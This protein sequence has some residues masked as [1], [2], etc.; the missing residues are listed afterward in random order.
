ME[1]PLIFLH[2]PKTGGT[3]FHSML[4]FQYLGRPSI[5]LRP[6]LHTDDV[7]DRRRA[8]ELDELDDSV[9]RKLQ[10]VRGHAYYG[11]HEKMPQACTYFTFVRDP[12]SH[13]KSQYYY[14]KVKP[15]E[16]RD[17][18]I[19]DKMSLESILAD[20]GNPWLDNMQ[21]RWISGVGL[22]KETI[23]E[24]EYRLAQRNVENHFSVLGVT[25][26]FDLSV[27]L[28]AKKLNWRRPLF[29]RRANV[30]NFNEGSRKSVAEMPTELIK[31]TNTWDLRLY[32]WGKKR[33]EREVSSD[34]EREVKNMKSNNVVLG[35]AVQA[36]RKVRSVY[37]QAIKPYIS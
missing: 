11:V 6:W 30:Q 13:V 33:L 23:G 34:V 36:V 32:K 28:L 29:Y 7:Y 5:R 3:T 35:P 9:K 1:T 27:A 10:L 4:T 14:F 20:E 17:A 19:W 31:E 22:G 24:D 18:T 25:D 37:R 21:V 15:H 16:N 8:R 12:I 26:Q 2:V